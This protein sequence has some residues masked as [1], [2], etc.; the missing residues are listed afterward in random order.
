M[1]RQYI[2]DGGAAHVMAEVPQCASD[3]G[4]A[5]ARAF[6]SHAND[7]HLDLSHDPRAPSPTLATPVVLLCHELPEPAKEC[8]WTNDGVELFQSCPAQRLGL[9]RQQTSLLVREP[10][11]PSSRLE[12]LLEDAI[13]SIQVVDEELLLSIDDARDR[14]HQHMPRLDNEAHPRRI[15]WATTRSRR[16]S[17]GFKKRRWI[18]GLRSI[19]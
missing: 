7:E 8:V 14:E 13:L 2:G 11:P 5:P 4:V 17:C 12:L 1:A 6:T 3:P 10:D 16:R 19:Q 18:A 9:D 15:P